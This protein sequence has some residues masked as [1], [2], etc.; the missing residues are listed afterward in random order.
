MRSCFLGFPVSRRGL[1]T[2]LEFQ[3]GALLAVEEVSAPVAESLPTRRSFAGRWMLNTSNQ[4]AKLQI[5]NGVASSVACAGLCSGTPNCCTYWAYDP[6]SL[7]QSEP[8]RW[9]LAGKIPEAPGGSAFSSISG[10]NPSYAPEA[11]AG[12]VWGF[13]AV[14]PVVTRAYPMTLSACM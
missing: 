10:F 7:S 1:A 8:Y 11:T 6:A 12:F 4:S 9:I 14:Y 3:V 2:G 13:R 5:L